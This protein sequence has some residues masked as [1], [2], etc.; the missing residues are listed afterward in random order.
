MDDLIQKYG[1]QTLKAIMKRGNKARYSEILEDFPA[2]SGTLS[3]VLKA[4]EEEGLIE[5]AVDPNSRPPI[6]YYSVTKK[7]KKLIASDVIDGMKLFSPELSEEEREA[8][9]RWIQHLKQKYGL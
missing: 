3:R 4:L 5:R 1:I 2:T 9:E 7:G 8:V 6:S